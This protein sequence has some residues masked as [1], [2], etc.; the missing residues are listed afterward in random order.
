MHHPN[1]SATEGGRQYKR[2]DQV[3]RC[4]IEVRILGG[5]WIALRIDEDFRQRNGVNGGL[6]P[7][8]DV[9]PPRLV[10]TR[11]PLGIK[12]PGSAKSASFQTSH[13]NDVTFVRGRE[14]CAGRYENPRDQPR[15]G[16]TRPRACN[17]QTHELPGRKQPRVSSHHAPDRQTRRI[18]H[19]TQPGCLRCHR[20]FPQNGYLAP[21]SS[22]ASNLISALLPTRAS[23][24][25]PGDNNQAREADQENEESENGHCAWLLTAN[26]P[27][28]QFQKIRW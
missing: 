20:P 11:N 25:P 18:G 27:P 14:D 13:I 5:T 8:Q 10:F 16:L 24:S 6:H 3:F 4:P 23:V 17:H 19:D 12:Y 22:L 9:P 7:R 21:C 2:S 1:V 28:C 15:R 26:N